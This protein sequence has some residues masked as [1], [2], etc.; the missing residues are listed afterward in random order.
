[1][2][3]R[4][5]VE[6]EIESDECWKIGKVLKRDDSAVVQSEHLKVPVSFEFCTNF[7]SEISSELDR[8]DINDVDQMRRGIGDLVSNGGD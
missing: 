7:W 2:L 5:R 3:A 6:D 4:D 8:D 1:M